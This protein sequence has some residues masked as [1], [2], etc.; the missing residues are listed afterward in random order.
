MP[1]PSPT[2]ERTWQTIQTVTGKDTGNR[3]EKTKL[4]K[5]PADW[6]LTWNCQGI[7]GVDDW[8]YIAIYHANG[9]LYNAGAQITCIAAKRVIGSVEELQSGTIYFS[10]DANT[11]WT[12]AIQ[13][14]V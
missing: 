13:K 3:T 11:N 7:D 4:F 9:K 2:P 1:T 14:P 12:I 10:I 6:Q 5:V 8:L